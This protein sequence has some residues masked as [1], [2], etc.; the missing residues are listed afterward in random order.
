M[1]MFNR[2]L[3]RALRE[4]AERA[5]ADLAKAREHLAGIELRLA[6]RAVLV[7]LIRDK[8]KVRFVFERNGDLT[9]IEA[10]I[11]LDQGWDELE[12]RLLHHG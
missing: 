9:Q 3:I 5:E 8:R 12:R 10:Y 1:G 4:R 6:N 7:S 2:H 11:T